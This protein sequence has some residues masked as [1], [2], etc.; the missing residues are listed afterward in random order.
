[1]PAVVRESMAD[2]AFTTTVLMIA[3]IVALLLGA[4]GLYGVIGY[5]VTQRTQEIGV[6]IAIG[7]RPEQVRTMVLREG[8][9][10]AFIGIAIGTIAA[11]ALTR[12]L[13]SALYEVSRLDPLTFVVVPVVLL[14]TSA[15]AAYVPARRAA[16][17]A[18]LEA[19]RTE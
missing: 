4:I 5:V 1:M 19:L 16:G 13:E 14:L 18:P 7:A 2:T 10:L 9:V 8:L 3:A 17:I 12:G 15:M 11:A 6:R